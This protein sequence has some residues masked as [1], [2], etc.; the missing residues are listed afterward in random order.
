[1]AAPQRRKQNNNKKRWAVVV[2][3]KEKL[4]STH[5]FYVAA[6]IFVAVRTAEERTCKGNVLLVMVSIVSWMTT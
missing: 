1:L 6:E 4:H 3:K 2:E 5:H